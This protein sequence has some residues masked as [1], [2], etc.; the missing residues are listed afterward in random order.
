M[1]AG[2]EL[3]GEKRVGLKPIFP[4]PI[5][6]VFHEVISHSLMKERVNE[7]GASA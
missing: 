5:I 3:R 4:M 1:V 6:I 2:G 7:K